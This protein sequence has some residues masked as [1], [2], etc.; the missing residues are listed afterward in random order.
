MK[1]K[2]FKSREEKREEISAAKVITFKQRLAYSLNSTS[3]QLI[4]IY[5]INGVLWI[6][7]SYILAFMDKIAIAET[8]SSNV[9]TIII[10]QIGFYLITKTIENVF[11]YNDF[12]WAKTIRDNPNPTRGMSTPEPT[13]NIPEPPN[14]IVTE[15]EINNGGSADQY[16]D[17]GTTDDAC[18]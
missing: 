8:L 1:I 16:F 6:W 9:C 12:P 10:G 5:T 17:T 15:E 4:W 2:L 7:C 18:G 13:F 3:K 14:T 11:K